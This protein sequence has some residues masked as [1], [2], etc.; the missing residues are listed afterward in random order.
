MELDDL[1]DDLLA[2]LVMLEL[3]DDGLALDLGI[4]IERAQFLIREHPTVPGQEIGLEVPDAT[5]AKIV[6]LLESVMVAIYDCLFPVCR[7]ETAKFRLACVVLR[8]GMQAGT[9]APSKRQRIEIL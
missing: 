1:G 4:R 2:Q 7:R 9:N 8:T 6:D 5:T 3:N